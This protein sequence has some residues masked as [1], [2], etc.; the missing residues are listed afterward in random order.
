M[1]DSIADSRL[2][3]HRIFV[4]ISPGIAITFCEYS[5]CILGHPFYA[6]RTYA[7]AG[8]NHLFISVLR[9]PRNAYKIR[10]TSLPHPFIVRLLHHHI[11][12]FHQYVSASIYDL[13]PAHT[14]EI[15]PTR[16]YRISKK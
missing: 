13:I 3:I 1:V 12:V 9:T 7:V 14:N 5:V 6:Y 2:W 16:N 11:F 8:G 10:Q 15:K 4:R